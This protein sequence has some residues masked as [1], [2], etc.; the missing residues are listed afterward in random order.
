MEVTFVAFLLCGEGP[1]HA[2]PIN[3]SRGTRLHS[4]GTAPQVSQ[5]L[6]ESI[7]SRFTNA[8]TRYHGTPK[9]HHSAKE[10]AYREHYRARVELFEQ[11]GFNSNY[12]LVF[13]E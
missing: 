11:Q 5:L 1:V 6:G 7:R 10:G 9:V 4:I 3:A 8:P 2:T 12:S 13:Y